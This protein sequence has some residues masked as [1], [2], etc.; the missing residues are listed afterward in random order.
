MR[1][2]GDPEEGSAEP[3]HGAAVWT[4]PPVRG[5]MEED[6]GELG[7]TYRVRPMPDPVHLP[8]S[9]RAVPRPR[10][11]APEGRGEPEKKPGRRPSGWVGR[12]RV[13]GDGCAILAGDVPHMVP[14]PALG[15]SRSRQDGRGGRRQDA[16]CIPPSP[17]PGTWPDRGAVGD[18]Q[19]VPDRA[20]AKRCG[21]GGREGEE[22]GPDTLQSGMARRTTPMARMHD[23]PV[24]WK[25]A[26]AAESGESGREGP[27]PCG[28]TG[29]G[30]PPHR[31]TPQRA[32]HARHGPS[33]PPSCHHGPHMLRATSKLS[34]LLKKAM[35][36]AAGTFRGA[37]ATAPAWPSGMKAATNRIFGRTAVG[38]I[39]IYGNVRSGDM[40]FKRDKKKHA[41]LILSIM[42]MVTGG[43]TFAIPGAEPASAEDMVI[44]HN[45]NAPVITLSGDS[46]FVVYLGEE[47][48][49][50]P[51]ATC[52]DNLGDSLP[53]SNNSATTVRDGTSG[54]YTVTYSCTDSSNNRAAPV[55]RTVYVLNPI[56]PTLIVNGPWYVQ[57]P[58]GI[59]YN[60]AG[61]RCVDF[62]DVDPTLT[63]SSTVDTSRMGTH[64]VTYTC[65]DEDGNQVKKVRLV[66][67]TRPDTVPP[68][69]EINGSTP[70]SVSQGNAYSDPGVTCTDNMDPAPRVLINDTVDTTTPGTYTITYTCQDSSGNSATPV[71]RIVNVMPGPVNAAPTVTLNGGSTI[72]I[73][74]GGTYH[75]QGATCTDDTDPNVPASILGAVDTTTPGTYTITYTCQDSSGNSATPVIRIVNVMPGPVNAAPTVT[76]NGGS[77][78]TIMVGGTYHEQGATCTD[79]TD[80]DPTLTIRGSEDVDTST[81]GTYSVTYICTDAT[82]NLS[83][84][85][86]RTI[87]VIPSAANGDPVLMLNGDSE[88]W[89]SRGGTY[90]EQGATC[91]DDTDPNPQV[92]ILGAVDTTTLGTYTITYT[93]Q[94]SSGNT[95]APVAR[96]VNVDDRL[97]LRTVTV[98]NWDDGVLTLSVTGQTAVPGV[99]LH[100]DRPIAGFPMGVHAAFGT[101]LIDDSIEISD[102]TL[103]GEVTFTLMS[104]Y[105]G[106]VTSNS[107]TVAIPQALGLTNVELGT[108]PEEEDHE[109]IESELALTIN[110]TVGVSEVALVAYDV[111]GNGTIAETIPLAINRTTGSIDTVE[112]VLTNI[113]LAG[114]TVQFELMS[115]GVSSPG[116]VG[117]IDIPA[118]LRLESIE[119]VPHDDKDPKSTWDPT[120]ERLNMVIVGR[121][122]V[123]E[124]AEI[125]LVARTADG[126]AL[127]DDDAG[128]LAGGKDTV[129]LDDIRITGDT[130]FRLNYTDASGN[131]TMSNAKSLNIPEVLTLSNVKVGK[132]WT[133]SGLSLNITGTELVNNDSASPIVIEL[134]RGGGVL[135]TITSGNLTEGMI[136]TLT[137]TSYAGERVKFQL[138]YKNADDQIVIS[139]LPGRVSIPPIA[140]KLDEVN[141]SHWTAY[142]D[143]STQMW[144]TPEGSVGSFGNEDILLK[145]KHGNTWRT[146]GAGTINNNTDSEITDS[147]LL[148]VGVYKGPVQFRMDVGSIS[149]NT[150]T[151][152]VPP[153]LAVESAVVPSGWTADKDSYR[154]PLEITGYANATGSVTV[155]AA[156]SSDEIGGTGNTI[157]GGT[158]SLTPADEDYTFEADGAYV[159]NSTASNE[160][161]SFW[162]NLDSESLVE[163]F[164]YNVT[165]PSALI[166]DDLT[167]G[168][169]NTLGKLKVD[170]AGRAFLPGVDTVVLAMYT[171]M[172]EAEKGS[173]ALAP[174]GFPRVGIA[175][176]ITD[177]V[178]ADGS[179]AISEELFL[180]NEDLAERTVY[181]R[182]EASGTDETGEARDFMIHSDA[183]RVQLPPI[184]GGR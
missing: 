26:G 82:Q 11:T 175:N 142:S 18:D 61:A 111:A 179:F 174:E 47:T 118:I 28:R 171:S 125:S 53:V 12:G 75:E 117:E 116:M 157:L 65:T 15:R 102:I 83:V 30:L 80:P 7:T 46:I 84:E 52:V 14:G 98:D 126:Y 70:D 93:C 3:G 173:L 113:S 145:A 54:V 81:V 106:Q 51:G 74:V 105:A 115:G 172:A 49:H 72:T 119:I 121:E 89:L 180:S 163:S 182:L 110:G 167:V 32:R 141:T 38:I 128:T 69:L 43:L 103:Y 169:W 13:S 19:E 183:Y 124:G 86:T 79:D 178:N 151:A 132:E 55:T 166:L 56:T 147:A 29:R 156:G 8:G 60:D 40:Q 123:T 131:S 33:P 158:V 130:V 127:V 42:I 6:E 34:H 100:A 39:V 90:Y 67:V 50:E 57:V 137:D 101:G 44:S 17:C 71:I 160:V 176:A 95:A 104:T 21:V 139:E 23:Y 24:V 5:H 161:I 1:P 59:Q 140:L 94:D 107:E 170:V 25:Q 64:V 88:V 58:I 27:P 122:N 165:I 35:I 10:N 164:L 129:I 85:I 22:E 63:T 99:T 108:H 143:G 91:T 112:H 162:M 159:T 78:I 62:G 177:T 153:A 152:D 76:L 114:K 20:P 138:W 9:G 149:S 148:L 77:T 87:S 68:V 155:R 120:N 31:A 37:C 97:V 184:A 134:N 48:Y 136:R 109:W 16:V 96:T 181:L 135:D 4:M 36:N 41:C 92:S 45:P 168:E 133:S 66:A 2:A 146:V 150:V 73:M 154:L 144:V